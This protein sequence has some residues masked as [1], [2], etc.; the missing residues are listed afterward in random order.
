MP[1]KIA[2]EKFQAIDE[3]E[4]VVILPKEDVE[5]IQNNSLPV[6]KEKDIKYLIPEAPKKERKPP[7]EAQLEARKKFAE[8]AREKAEARKQAKLK[9]E[10]EAKNKLKAEQQALLDSGTHV[11]VLIKKHGNAGRKLPKSGSRVKKVDP[12]TDTSDLDTT[13]LDTTDLSDT[14]IDDYKT[15]ARKTRVQAKKV[16]RTIKKIDRVLQQAPP[17]A[18][19][20]PYTAILASRWR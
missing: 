7:S 16:V 17:A 14:D 6:I 19:Q 11:K 8:Y 18:P 13:D 20:N 9:E 12:P 15:K 5:K 4:N 10:E 2:L 1:K 3:K